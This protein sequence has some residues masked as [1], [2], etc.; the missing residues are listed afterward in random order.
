[1]KDTAPAGYFNEQL[2]LVTNDSSN[3]RIPLHVEGRVVP[4]ISVA[5]EAA[6]VWRRG[7][8][9]TVPMKVLVRGKKPF[10]I[11]SVDSPSGAFDFKT[12]DKSSPRHVV[13]VVF[14]GKQNPG[15][16][17]E[18]IH[19]TTD[20]GE[21]FDATLTA[22]ATV[23]PA[24]TETPGH[25]TPPPRNPPASPLPATKVPPTAS[26]SVQ[27]QWL[28]N[29]QPIRRWQP[30]RSTCGAACIDTARSARHNPAAFLRTSAATAGA[31][32]RRL[33]SDV[34]R[35]VCARSRWRR[36]WCVSCCELFVPTAAAR[37]SRGAWCWLLRWRAAGAGFPAL[38]GPPPDV[39][40]AE[41]TRGD[42]ADDHHATK[43]RLRTI[44]RPSRNERSRRE[45]RR[46]ERRRLRPTGRATKA[47]LRT[48]TSKEQG[49]PYIMQQEGGA[50]QP[51]SFYDPSTRL[52]PPP[53]TYCP[54][55]T[56]LGFRHSYTHGR[57]V[58]WGG[59]LVGSSWL[60]RPYY[61]GAT[62][63]PMWLT[64]RVADSRATRRR[65][66]RQLIFYGWE[67]DYYWGSEFQ[68]AYATPELAQRLL[69]RKFRPP[70]GW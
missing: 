23:L 47:A 50:Y 42:E 15:P 59:P 21:T 9:A 12:D 7:Q 20:L 41:S 32:N 35:L 11:I 6:A 33:T 22:Y 29:Q 57:N 63:G 43:N 8:G 60:N 31:A 13:E 61:V 48:T 24:A 45:R 5:P 51:G 26:G 2:V 49:L 70:V 52:P 18:T 14:A 27:A 55:M 3:P 54:C 17:K 65:R 37:L 68:Y 40:M 4:E 1:M 46:A 36:E 34:P 28:P 44:I 66:D 38:D 58:G 19:I 64:N 39:R 16:V 56:R 30:H 25:G 10:K 69:R 67:W 62:L 53:T